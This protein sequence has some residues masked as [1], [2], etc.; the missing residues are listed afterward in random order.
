MTAVTRAAGVT[1][2]TRFSRHRLF[3]VRQFSRDIKI[4]EL[5]QKGGGENKY[6]RS[7]LRGF[8]QYPYIMVARL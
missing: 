1:S 6:K 3:C 2:Y 8:C 5:E 4:V 7:Y